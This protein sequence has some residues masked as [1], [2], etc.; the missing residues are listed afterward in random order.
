MI[1]DDSIQN[2]RDLEAAKT[3]IAG[4]NTGV[5]ANASGETCNRRF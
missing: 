3:V 2:H 5:T 4:S 1:L